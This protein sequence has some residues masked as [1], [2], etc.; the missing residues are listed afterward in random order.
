MIYRFSSVDFL[1]L[2]QAP[3]KNE[4]ADELDSAIVGDEPEA[5]AAAAAEPTPV[6][7]EVLTNILFF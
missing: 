5:E 3:K 4:L 6:V 1:R 2:L 7:T